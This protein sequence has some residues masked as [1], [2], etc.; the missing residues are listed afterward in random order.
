MEEKTKLSDFDFVLPDELIAQY[1]S[2][3][4]GKE[5]LLRVSLAGLEHYQFEDI[6]K[7][8]GEDDLIVLNNTKVLK[9]RLRGLKDSGGSCEIMVERILG[10]FEQ[11]REAHCQIRASKPIKMLSLIH[12]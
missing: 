8:I 3:T 11:S 6:F 10:D 7:L 9:A 4:R 2:E 1:P 5:R 12:I